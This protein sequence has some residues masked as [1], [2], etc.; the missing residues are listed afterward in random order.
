MVYLKLKQLIIKDCARRFVLKLYRHKASR[1]LFAIAEI[2]VKS[3]LMLF[4]KKLSKLVHACRNY[5][6]PKLARFFETQYSFFMSNI[7]AMILRGP[8]NGGSWGGGAEIA[9]LDE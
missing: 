2:L 7:V 8:P 9:I 4:T 1:G 5:R 6:L 3:V